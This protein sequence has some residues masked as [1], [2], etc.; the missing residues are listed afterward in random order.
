VIAEDYVKTNHS[1]ERRDVMKRLCAM[2]VGV[3]L[4]VFLI[5]SVN[6][7][8]ESTSGNPQAQKGETGGKKAMKS[9]RERQQKVR[10]V[11]KQASAMRQK[12]LYGNSGTQNQRSGK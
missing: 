3:F 6:A 12:A 11:K 2:A 10:E 5:A 1:G 4:S 9:M 7:A 8:P